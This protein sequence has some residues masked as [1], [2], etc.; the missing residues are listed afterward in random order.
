MDIISIFSLQISDIYHHIPMSIQEKILIIANP[1]S[2]G[3]RGGK[4]IPLVEK[5][6]TESG[7]SYNLEITE[8][9]NHGYEIVRNSDISG[10]SAVVSLGGDGTNYEVLNGLMKNPGIEDMPVL[11]VIPVG[12]GNSFA[13][14]LDINTTEEGISSIVK[15][16]TKNVDLC[17]YTQDGEYF[18][19]VNL[20]GF[21]FVTDAAKTA[22]G[23]KWLG[24]MSYI[25]GVLHKTIGLRFH[26]LEIEI[27][28]KIFTGK[29]CFVEICNSRYTGGTM[30]M[31]P[32]S[33]IDDGYM[34][35]VILSVLSRWS[36]IKTFPRIF[37]GTHLSHPAIEYK[38]CRKVRIS[39][40]PQKLLL[41]DGELKGTTPTEV[42]I[43]PGHLRYLY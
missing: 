14:D 2:G 7:I 5:R 42:D 24:A 12:S 23:F 41:P 36:L 17:R 4:V 34:D 37:K 43:L 18:Y 32:D 22:A 27:D 3:K 16:R 20:M 6:L 19:F 1:Y 28:G 8:Y 9:Q 39:T 10:Y 25:L 35:I 40:N 33:K 29:N 13:R 38:R 11:G 15:K 31:S 26:Q 21:G 30:L